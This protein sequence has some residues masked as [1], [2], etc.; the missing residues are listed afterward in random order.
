M[1]EV[2]FIFLVFLSLNIVAQPN[3]IEPDLINVD[4][5]TDWVLHGREL[6][7]DK[8]IHFNAKPEDG[9]L[10]LKD[11]N[12]ANGSIELDIKGKNE[13]GKSFVGIAFH[14]LNDSVYDVVYFRAFNFTNP[15]RKNHSVQYISHP[16]HTW[17]SLRNQHP[18]EYE[19]TINPIPEPNDWFLVTIEVDFPMVKAFVNNASEPSLVINQLSERKQGWVGFWAGYGSAG[20]Y[21][22]LKIVPSK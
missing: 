1:K 20:S 5:V 10:W 6:T 15:E 2:N 4:T 16:N 18:E 3:L 11:V 7:I 19:S 22:N 9:L 14:G 21:R 8:G 12:F 13:Q 17:W